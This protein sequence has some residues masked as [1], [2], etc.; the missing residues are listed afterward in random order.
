[1]DIVIRNLLRDIQLLWLY[2]TRWPSCGKSNFRRRMLSTLNKN[3]ISQKVLQFSLSQHSVVTL[4]DI[5]VASFMTS[6]AWIVFLARTVNII[7]YKTVI[8]NPIKRLIYREIFHVVIQLRTLQI[9]L[10]HLQC[11]LIEVETLNLLRRDVF[12]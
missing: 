7:A 11:S 4:V 10:A 2:S 12:D 8:N 6:V 5:T 9:K 3:K 1:M